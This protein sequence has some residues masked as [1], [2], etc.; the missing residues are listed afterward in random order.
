MKPASVLFVSQHDPDPV[1]DGGNHR[2]YQVCRDLAAAAGDGRVVVV[3][4]S[5]WRRSQP[6]PG[7]AQ[8][9]AGL[10]AGL[11][12]RGQQYAP[13][14][15][16][17]RIVRSL[18]RRISRLHERLPFLTA[19]HPVDLLAGRGT[20]G[21]TFFSWEFAAHYQAIAERAQQP[22]VC[23]IEHASF[24]QLVPINRRLGIPT[25]SCTQNLEAFDTGAPIAAG[26]GR[27]VYLSAIEFADE[28]SLLAQ[29]AAHLFISKAEAAIFGGLGLPSRYYPYLP[30]GDVRAA[31]MRVRAARTR[32]P[33]EPGLLLM[34]GSAG[35]DTTRQ[36]FAWFIEHAGRA[37]LPEGVRVV[38][39]GTET[40][41][42]L[43]PGTTV[44]GLEMR[45]WLQQDE[46]DGL[47]ARAQAV[48]VPQMIGFG[49]LTRLPELAC[50]GIPTIV[51]RHPCYAIE[52]PPGLLV[53]EDDWEAWQ[54]GMRY[55]LSNRID[56]PTSDYE[57]WERRQ[58]SPLA[59]AIDDV[60]KEDARAA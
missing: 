18:R 42:L 51:S 10:R 9:P 30:V 21:R 15:A 40:D 29:C 58:E 11:R 20:V 56:C 1:G 46:L 59:R 54:A 7:V 34:L 2:A 32:G 17:A 47:M 16:A 50:A 14:R 25:V 39:G 60:L 3:S 55:M 57:A 28:Y 5:R 8:A 37:G 53:V 4:W 27:K 41:K 52:P 43:P 6:L 48:L 45:G 35:H 44:P 23:I 19:G 36:A 49:A 38:V 22:A 33:I 31:L 26:D 24:A 12:R 13:A